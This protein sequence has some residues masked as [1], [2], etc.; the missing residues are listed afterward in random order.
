METY[1]RVIRTLFSYL[2]RDEMIGHNPMKKVKMPRLPRVA[3]PT[4]SQKDVEILLSQL[5]KKT[6]TGF[7]DYAIMLT[8][9]SIPPPGCL[10]SLCSRKTTSTW[11]TDT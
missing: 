1:A 6:N 10:K 11:R 7:K 3:V 2:Y 5:D 8:F 9:I 4:F